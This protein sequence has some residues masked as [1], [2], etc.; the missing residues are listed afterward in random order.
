MFELFMHTFLLEELYGNGSRP[1][2]FGK[3]AKIALPCIDTLIRDWIREVK[4]SL[5]FLNLHP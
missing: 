4:L 1:E 5:C 2:C 3:V